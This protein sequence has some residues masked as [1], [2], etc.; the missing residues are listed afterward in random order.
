MTNRDYAS[1]AGVP[2]PTLANS[3]HCPAHRP[4]LRSLNLCITMSLDGRLEHVQ[5]QVAVFAH[6]E[7]P[8]RV[9]QPLRLGFL[10]TSLGWRWYSVYEKPVIPSRPILTLAPF[11]R[12]PGFAF[13]SRELTLYWN[14]DFYYQNGMN[15]AST[16]TPTLRREQQMADPAPRRFDATT[17]QGQE[18]PGVAA[19][20]SR[21]RAA[22][23]VA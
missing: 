21:S 12:K 15:T 14:A 6:G 20:T 4:T 16:R 10:E 19:R 23:A 5:V 18:H 3:T 2:C 8:S 7:A 9:L 17:G 11:N 22:T 1:P 13:A